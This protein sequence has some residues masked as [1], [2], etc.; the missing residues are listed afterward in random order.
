MKRILT[1]LIV[2]LSLVLL[3]GVVGCTST[4]DTAEPATET[5]DA[6]PPAPA[7]G[8]VSDSDV[9][10]IE[11]KCSLCHTTER[12]WSAGYDRAAWEMTVDRM[13]SNGLVLTDEEYEQIVTY[14]ADQ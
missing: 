10:L 4:S 5:Q 2:I 7:D 1:T 9:A 3:L 14:L 8:E 13:K 6:A 11:N 12:V